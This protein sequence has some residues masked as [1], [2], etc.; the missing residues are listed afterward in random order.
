MLDL[1]DG[2][3]GKTEDMADKANGPVNQVRDTVRATGTE[4]EG[5]PTGGVGESAKEIVQAV[6]ANASELA[7]KVKD[8]AQQWASSVG[9]AAV[10]AK[11]KVGDAA[12]AADQ[13]M[14]PRRW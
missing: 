13:A 12:S 6:A 1:K 14:P 8:T 3:Q 7:G 4:P 10:Q 5:S 2:N 11:D 9:G